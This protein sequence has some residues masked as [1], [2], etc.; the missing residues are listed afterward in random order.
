MQSGSSSFK[1]LVKL[2]GQPGRLSSRVLEASLYITSIDQ[3]QELQKEREL[4]ISE[5]QKAEADFAK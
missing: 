3:R 2:E 5:V 1:R 4:R